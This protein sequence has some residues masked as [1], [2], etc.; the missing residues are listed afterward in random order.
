MT[1]HEC[2]ECGHAFETERG[3]RVHHWRTHGTRLPNR[4]CARC[5]TE[6]YS[7]HS[8]KYCS[9]SCREAS[10]TRSGENNPNYRG[11]KT[12]TNCQ[13]CGGEF[14]Y[15]P[16]AKDGLYC[17]DCVETEEWRTTPELDG[18]SNPRW[19]GGKR[20]LECAVCGTTVERYPSNIESVTV[21]SETCR[22]AWLSDAFTGDGHP[23]WKGGDTGPYGKGWNAIRR[24][25]LER[26]GYQCK[27]CGATSEELGR[28]PDVHHITPIRTYIESEEHALEDAHR[29]DNVVSL[30]SSCHRKAEFGKIPKDELRSMIDRSS[31]FS[32]D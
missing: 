32:V 7:E 13:L 15:Y 31:R 19:N 21:C 9:R 6:F 4:T 3:L 17:P 25:A 28:N 30:C 24:Q 29:L 2:P 23:N 26:D 27:H 20:K 18:D 8:K 11:G 10:V 1:D 12:T 22:R 14:E 16:S 5:G